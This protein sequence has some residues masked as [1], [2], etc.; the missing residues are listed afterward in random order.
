MFSAIVYSSC[1]GSCR[2]YAEI[3]SSELGI[4][5]L[6][7]EKARIGRDDRIIYIG[8]LM[9]GKIKGYKKALEKFNIGAV[10]QVGMSPATT[11]SEE[12]GRKNN[13]VSVDI[14]LFTLQGAFDIKK[15]PLPYR[16][17]M[18]AVTKS[19]AEKLGA[20]A[21]LTE[22][23]KATLKMARDGAGEPAAWCVSDIVEWCRVH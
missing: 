12:Q 2:R 5:A 17:I 10:A 23:E 4:P 11:E 18:K 21:E 20:K 15:L 14:P 13:P 22:Q 19:I 7:I 6:P 3:L 8:W 9:A 16:L 1:T